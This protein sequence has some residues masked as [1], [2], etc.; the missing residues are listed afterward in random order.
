MI[1]LGGVVPPT[2]VQINPEADSFVQSYYGTTNYG[3]LTYFGAGVTQAPNKVRAFLRFDLTSIPAG[4]TISDAK[5]YMSV[6]SIWGTVADQ[7]KY[8]LH[9]VSDDTWGE[10]TITSNNQPTRGAAL[11]SA[12]Q[13]STTGWKNYSITTQV[14]TEYEGD[15]KI[16]LCWD[17]NPENTAK[18]E[19]FYAYSKDHPTSTNWPYLEVTYS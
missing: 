6:W 11:I 8:D 7:R 17:D 18:Y 9:F 13:I 5:L 15:G 14:K 4:K 2:T 16:S 19:G 1:G 12:T 3:S 10:L